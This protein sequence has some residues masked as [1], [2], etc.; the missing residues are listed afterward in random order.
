MRTTTTRLTGTPSR[1][2]ARTP[3]AARTRPR[4]SRQP[5]TCEAVG[6]SAYGT[7]Q[8]GGG[9]S[10]RS[11][12][13]FPGTTTGVC[14][15]HRHRDL[16]YTPPPTSTTARPRRS[17]TNA[18]ACSPPPSRPHRTAFRCRRVGLIQ[19]P[20]G[21]AVLRWL[22]TRPLSKSFGCHRPRRHYHT[23]PRQRIG[24]GLAHFLLSRAFVISP[25]PSL[26]ARAGRGA[27]IAQPRGRLSTRSLGRR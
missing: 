5:E 13:S 11:E 27:M 14:G 24:V 3:R 20:A 10:P 2:G 18:A 26:M 8:T 1:P 22:R 6:R 23:P 16:A 12:S 9:I 21:S 19:A 25:R 4:T 17:A 7:T 15:L